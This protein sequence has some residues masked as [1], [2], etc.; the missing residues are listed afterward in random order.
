MRWLDHFTT[1]DPGRLSLRRAAHDGRG[2][3]YG[4]GTA[5]MLAIGSV[6]RDEPPDDLRNWG[7]RRMGAI[8]RPARV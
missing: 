3:D 5:W 7:Y 4:R 8:R 6:L 1:V 2:V